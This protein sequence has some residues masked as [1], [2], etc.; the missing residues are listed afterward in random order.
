MLFKVKEGNKDKSNKLMSSCIDDEKLLQQYKAISTNVE[1][2]KSIGLN[3]LPVYDDKYI[4]TKRRTIG[5][6]FRMLNVPEDDIK[7]ESFIV[8]PLILYLYT[9]TNIIRKYV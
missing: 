6:N 2:L 1:D 3:A 4:K 7:C 5:D 9:T 8:F